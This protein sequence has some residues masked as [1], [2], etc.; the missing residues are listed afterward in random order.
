LSYIYKF[1]VYTAVYTKS[2]VEG[3]VEK[4]E[5]FTNFCL[6]FI[7]FLYLHSHIEKEVLKI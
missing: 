2:G 7:N 5:L 4:F 1:Y 6:T 3:L